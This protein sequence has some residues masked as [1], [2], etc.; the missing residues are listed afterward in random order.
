M[1]NKQAEAWKSLEWYLSV[2]QKDAGE[3]S[4]DHFRSTIERLHK[5]GLPADAVNDI[6]LLMRASYSLGS[7]RKAV[8]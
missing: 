3:K 2:M 1:T 7:D 5:R 8:V 6:A 4:I